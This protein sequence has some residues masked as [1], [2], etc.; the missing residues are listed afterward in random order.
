MHLWKYEFLKEKSGS[1]Q[2]SAIFC[3]GLIFL[4][5][6]VLPRL[7]LVAANVSSVY[8]LYGSICIA[9]V[10]AYKY[11]YSLA[12]RVNSSENPERRRS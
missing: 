1:M 7:L 2:I 6:S 3:G 9:P 12:G 5:L 10:C 8:V 4:H 11:A